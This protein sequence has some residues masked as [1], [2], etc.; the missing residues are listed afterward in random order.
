MSSARRLFTA[1]VLCL[2]ANSPSQDTLKVSGTQ[3]SPTEIEDTLLQHP[4]QLISD[5]AVVGVN[6]SR[7]TDEKVPR[8]WIV[9]TDA[10]KQRGSQAVFTAL[11]IW[12]KERLSRHKWLRGGYQ[13]V[14]E[15]S[16]VYVLVLNVLTD[17]VAQIPKLPTG[18]VLRR[19]LLDEYLKAQREGHVV[20]TK[21]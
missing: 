10:G 16:T 19:V 11:D 7:M 14:N 5:A 4:E 17:R 6:G 9:L 15:V 8:A 13:A 21:L 20:R 12:V 2:A 18:K 1:L 3:V